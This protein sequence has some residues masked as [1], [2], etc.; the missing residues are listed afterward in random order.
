MRY[1]LALVCPP[2][3]LLCCKKRYQA[4]IA[5]LLFGLAIA[6]ARFGVG[7][8]IDFFLILWASNVVGDERAR[9]EAREFVR[10]VRPIPIIRV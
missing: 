1:A 6:T 7:A 10:T 4:M 8:L 2:L 3:A 9:I 5:A